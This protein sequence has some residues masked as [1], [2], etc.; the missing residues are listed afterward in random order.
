MSGARRSAIEGPRVE[1]KQQV[2]LES[3]EMQGEDRASSIAGIYREIYVDLHAYVSID[4]DMYMYVY[5]Y[6]HMSV[7]V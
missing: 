3:E 2:A 1:A 6:L 5:M 4:V 7:Y